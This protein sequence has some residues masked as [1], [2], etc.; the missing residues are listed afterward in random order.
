M[1]LALIVARKEIR[2]HLRD[3]KSLLSSALLTLMGPGVVLI[4]SLSD[5]AA[6]QD[7]ARVLLG[8]LSIFALVSS[9]AGAIDIAMDSAAGERERRSLLPLLLNPI[10]RWSV[11]AGKWIAVAVRPAAL[12]STVLGWSRCSV[13]GSRGAHLARILIA[14]WIA[15][16]RAAG[17]TERRLE[18]A[19]GREADGQRGPH[20]AQIPC[21]RPDAGGMLLVFP[22]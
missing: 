6:G 17:V 1:T 5:R 3:R 2:D 15:R 22:A 21:V 9:F 12:A 14:A 10:P 4:V 8:M 18:P 11:L 20:R 7:K 16:S 19:R 13:G